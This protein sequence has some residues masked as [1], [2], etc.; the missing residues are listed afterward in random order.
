MTTA[1]NSYTEVNFDGLVGPSHNYSALSTGNIASLSHGGKASN[2]K[3]A[4]LQGLAKVEFLINRGFQQGI[5]LPQ[6]RP[7]ISFLKSHGF[8]GTDTEIVN[9]VFKSNPKLLSIAFSASSMW[10]ANA[11]TV[12]PSNDSEDGNLHFVVANLSAK[13]HR[14]QEAKWTYEYLK[15]VFA[16]DCF[17]VHPAL[18]GGEAFAD[19]GAAN[20]TRLSS[21]HSA[22]GVH[23]FTFGRSAWKDLPHPKKFVARQSLEASQSLSRLGTVESKSIFIQQNPAAIDAG[24]F[25]NDVICVGNENILFSHEKAFTDK[26]RKELKVFLKKNLAS[27]QWIEVKSSDVSLK[28]C[29]SSYLF[30]SQL[31]S[32]PQNPSQML[33][34]CP[35]ECQEDKIVKKYLDRLVAKNKTIKEW[36]TLDLR[37]SMRNGGGPACLR[38]RVQLSKNELKRIHPEALLNKETIEGLRKIVSKNYRDKLSVNDLRDPQLITEIRTALDEFTQLLKLG[39]LYD[40]QK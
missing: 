10:T 18:N 30:N 4:A 16:A 15:K 40:F 34:L 39:P 29:V 14:A 22:P 38:L 7:N 13:P 11:A 27:Y 17:R 8:C 36:K 5:F 24:V 9:N 28:K 6:E 1:E 19:E 37:Q 32:D 31:L 33:L 12:M 3:K 20:H 23:L 21:E 35:Q 26:S 25:H 2:P